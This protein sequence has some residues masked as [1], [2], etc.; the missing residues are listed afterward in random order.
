MQKTSFHLF[1]ASELFLFREVQNFH[2]EKDDQLCSIKATQ[3]RC[4]HKRG[5]NSSNVT[6]MW[7]WTS[8]LIGEK[9]ITKN[10]AFLCTID[11]NVQSLLLLAGKIKQNPK[12]RKAQREGSMSVSC[13][14]VVGALRYGEVKWKDRGMVCISDGFCPQTTLVRSYAY[15]SLFTIRLDEPTGWGTEQKKYIYILRKTKS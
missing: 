1:S 12:P 10:L 5:T 9:K 7:R 6:K 13:P 8:L 11:I 14:V 3:T 2:Q 4:Y 15:I